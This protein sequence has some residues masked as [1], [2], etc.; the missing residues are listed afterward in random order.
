LRAIWF[1]LQYDKYLG[2]SYSIVQGLAA[3]L[4]LV[5]GE[6]TNNLLRYRMRKLMLEILIIQRDTKDEVL[7]FYLNSEYYGNGI[8]GIGDAAQFY[9]GKH[10]SD[11]NLAECAMLG[12][13]SRFAG[14]PNFDPLEELEEA[15]LGQMN[16]LLLMVEEEYI[17][18]EEARVAMEEPLIFVHQ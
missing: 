3:N 18:A 9:Y 14:I 11:L 7:E 15:K 6:P 10:I 8:Y 16:V 13:L 4:M 12:Y 2:D 1:N 17:S 5:S